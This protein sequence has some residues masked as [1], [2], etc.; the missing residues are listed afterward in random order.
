[1]TEDNY[2]ILLPK[3]FGKYSVEFV[4]ANQPVR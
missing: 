2:K 1:M 3:T 4:T